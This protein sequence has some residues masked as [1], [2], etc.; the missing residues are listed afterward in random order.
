MKFYENYIKWEFT[1]AGQSEFQPFDEKAKE[2]K[3]AY[4]V[5]MKAYKQKL[6]EEGPT[7]SR[8]A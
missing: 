6:K 1:V 7:K 8:Y 4:D 3:E 5:A 2:A